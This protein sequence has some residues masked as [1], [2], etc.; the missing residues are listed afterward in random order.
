MA[1]E[2]NVSTQEDFMELIDQKDF[3]I[4]RAIVE[5]ILDNLD[6]KKKNVHVLTVNC[7]EENITFDLTVDTKFFAL[8]LEENLS[9]YVKEEKYE[10]CQKIV[11]AINQLKSKD[12]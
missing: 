8:T 3:R 11:N 5:S 9:Y 6:T 1:S 7:E 10:D 12:N 4:S 2:L